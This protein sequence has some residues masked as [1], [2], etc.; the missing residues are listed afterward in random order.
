MEVRALVSKYW[1]WIYSCVCAK[2]NTI[3]HY[4]I[5]FLAAGNPDSKDLILDTAQRC[6][7]SNRSKLYFFWPHTCLYHLQLKRVVH[8]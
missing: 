1:L 5:E 2:Y 4:W 7:D 3:A 8:P 6:S